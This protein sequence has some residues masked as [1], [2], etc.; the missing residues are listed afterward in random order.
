MN[1]QQCSL[2]LLKRTCGKLAITLQQINIFKQ[3]KLRDTLQSMLLFKHKKIFL[4]KSH[5][6]PDKN[7]QKSPIYS[8]LSDEKHNPLN[9]YCI[10]S[11]RF[12]KI[13]FFPSSRGYSET[14]IFLI[15]N[16]NRSNTICRNF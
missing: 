15:N 3:N 1:Q 7:S 16:M 6:F 2:T 12:S 13:K 14:S 9:S 11:R 8:F 4:I 5:N 10:H